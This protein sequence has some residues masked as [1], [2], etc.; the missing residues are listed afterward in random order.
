MG[1]VPNPCF[2][3]ASSTCTYKRI[4]DG[5]ALAQVEVIDAAWASVR[6]PWLKRVDGERCKER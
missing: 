5:A 6:V 3:L 4:S 1:T 2:A